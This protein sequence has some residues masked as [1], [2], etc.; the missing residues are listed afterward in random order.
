MCPSCGYSRSWS[1][2][3]RKKKCKKCRKEFSISAY[4]VPGFRATRE[5]WASAIHAF[6]RERT[7]LRAA[8]AAGVGAKTAQ[9]MVLLLRQRMTE[10]VPAPFLGIVEMDETYVGGQRKNKRLHIRRIRAK[11]GMGT[12]KLPIVGMF[13]R[14]TGE[15]IAAFEP[16]KL[17]IGFIRSLA[18]GRVVRGSTFYTDGLG[19]YRLLWRDGYLHAS[20][21]HDAGEY[22]R[23]DVHTNNIEGFWGIMKRRM[24]CIGGMRQGRF[25]YF[26]GEVVWRFN[27]R[28][29][30][31]DE[32]GRALLER[33]L[34]R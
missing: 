21:N 12:E 34:R 15:V 5:V 32:Q 23:L 25:N 22:V 7:F 33:V 26:V 30:P 18:K 3:R 2:R 13:S 19:M 6:L 28:H 11:R 17:D 29:L 24:S 27:H 16:K 1:L 14:E 9:R 8:E 31:L 10:D 20:V 4:P